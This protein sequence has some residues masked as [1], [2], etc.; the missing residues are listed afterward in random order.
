MK[1]PTFAELYEHTKRTFYLQTDQMA[2]KSYL[3]CAR[4]FPSPRVTL[5]SYF[6]LVLLHSKLSFI[7]IPVSQSDNGSGSY[8]QYG[9]LPSVA[10]KQQRLRRTQSPP[11]LGTYKNLH[12]PSAVCRPSAGPHGCV[13]QYRCEHDNVLLVPQDEEELSSSVSDLVDSERLSPGH[14]KLIL[15]GD[16]LIMLLI[17]SNVF[18]AVWLFLDPIVALR[19]GGL[20]TGSVFCDVSG[21][22]YALG[23]EA[24]GM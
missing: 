13:D 3:Q 1:L 14:I 18:R 22:L 7:F 24:S 21:F 9:G 17:Q 23:T 16:S 4:T 8:E 5:G 15:V 12:A 2:S 19:H 20:Q 11:L 10:I 6:Q